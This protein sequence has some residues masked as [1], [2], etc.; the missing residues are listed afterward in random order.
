M[1]ID[2][3]PTPPTKG[4]SSAFASHPRAPEGPGTQI[5]A[6]TTN[7]SVSTSNRSDTLIDFAGAGHD[8]EEEDDDAALKVATNDNTTA[9]ATVDS[10]TDD[11]DDSGNRSQILL[12][13]RK[14]PTDE[15]AA[16]HDH[17]NS[18]D[19]DTIDLNECLRDVVEDTEAFDKYQAAQNQYVKLKK[20]MIDEGTEVIVGKE[21]KRT[22]WKV[23][24]DILA[25]D[26][27]DCVP[28]FKELGIKGFDF[29]NKRVPE[30]RGK[31]HRI[32]LH[33]LMIH[34]WPGD[35]KVQLAFMNGMIEDKEY[36][37]RDAGSS[38][39]K[40]SLI[41]EREFWIFFGL[42]LAARLEGRV[43]TL[44]DTD[45]R[46]PD[47][48]LRNV[49]YS[50]H[51]SRTRFNEI[52]HYMA[53]LF[54]DKSQ[55]G[56]DDWWQVLGGIDGFNENRK[57]TVQA[58]N[59]RVLDES[60]SAFR[61]RTTKTGDLPYISFIMRKPEPLGTEFKTLAACHFGMYCFVPVRN[62]ESI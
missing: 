56:K 41:S 2:M 48:I 26:L 30:D 15:D 1:L 16:D 53:F 6:E 34:L 61:P 35:W 12:S 29:G 8:H 57:K 45:T 54:A 46:S 39:R 58:P 55:K 32:N 7:A 52:R 20:A 40:M 21:D 47:G 33:D 59:I 28:Y 14:T 27:P 5:S 49:N 24:D 17:D 3:A 13:P 38:M 44:W 19:E 25:K 9:D 4:S 31:S 18:F 36:V 51:M 23:Q 37:E 11:D 42:M 43:G 60:M 62:N 50:K 22:R 10:D